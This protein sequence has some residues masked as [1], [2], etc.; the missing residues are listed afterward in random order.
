[1][2]LIDMRMPDMKTESIPISTSML[3]CLSIYFI[4]KHKS[5]LLHLYLS[6]RSQCHRPGQNHIG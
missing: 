2:I 1:M 5:Y 6:I 3:N 4:I